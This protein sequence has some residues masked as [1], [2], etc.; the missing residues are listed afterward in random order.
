MITAKST[1]GLYFGGALM[2][3]LAVAARPTSSFVLVVTSPDGDA[4]VNM[5]VIAEAGGTFVWSGRYPWMT[6]A[7]SE[8]PGFPA[9]LL[10]AGAFLVL[11]HDLVVDCLKGTENE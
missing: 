8:E 11:N 9:R 5:S 7:Y 3:V 6:V 10:K 4:A 1:I 2:L